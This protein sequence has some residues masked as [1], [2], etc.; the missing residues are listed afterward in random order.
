MM[1][2]FCEDI[3]FILASNAY[4]DEMPHSVAFHQR[5]HWL[6]KYN[7]TDFNDTFYL[8]ATITQEFVNREL[9]LS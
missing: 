9:F 2:F 6:P 5:I 1:H 4:S 7:F 3:V 8:V